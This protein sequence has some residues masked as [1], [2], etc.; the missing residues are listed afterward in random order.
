MNEINSIIKEVYKPY[1]YTIKGKT[2]IIESTLGNFIIKAKEDSDIKALYSYLKS[3]DFLNMPNLIEDNRDEVNVFEYVE[4]VNMPNDL[5]GMDLIALVANLHNKT[6]F[7]K[8]VSMSRYTEIYNDIDDT[9][10]YYINYYNELI[11]VYHDKIFHSP[12]EYLFLRNSSKII[13]ALNYAKEELDSWY[14]LVKDVS[15]ERVC[16]IHNNLTIDHY[17]K[18]NKDVLVS[19]EKAK[20]DTP[21]MDLVNFYHHDYLLLDFAPIFNKYFERYNLLEHEKKLLYI[22]IAIPIEFKIYPDNIKTVSS[23]RHSFDYLYK[24]ENLLKVLNS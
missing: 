4:N 18:G 12:S 21:I 1:R 22:L 6:T 2:T 16:L 10:T 9:L 24:T 20:N 19:W 7:F 13:M 8:E 14:L 3:R 17:I 11:D 15:S 23:M 5:K